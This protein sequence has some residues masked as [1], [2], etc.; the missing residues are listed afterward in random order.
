MLLVSDSTLPCFWRISQWHWIA[1]CFA[2]PMHVE[3]QW[4]WQLQ[5]LQLWPEVKSCDIVHVDWWGGAVNFQRQW[6]D[7]LQQ[8]AAHTSS[9]RAVTECLQMCTKDA[10]A[11]N[12]P[13][14]VDM[15]LCHSGAKYKCTDWLTYLLLA[16]FQAG[17][18]R[19]Q[20]RLSHRSEQFLNGTSVHNRL[21]S[22]SWATGIFFQHGYGKS[23][24]IRSHME[25]HY[26]HSGMAS[27]YWCA[28]KQPL[29][30]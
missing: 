2:S 16:Y 5:Q 11:P 13:A 21:F 22:A 6:T 17:D 14:P 20:D 27:L 25:Q 28:R 29:S 18:F 24:S 26:A 30:H 8:S 19:K 12:C 15:F 4:L 1:H 23:E 9:I 7:H 10:P 3:H